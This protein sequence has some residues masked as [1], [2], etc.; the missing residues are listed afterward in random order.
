MTVEPVCLRMRGDF[1]GSVHTDGANDRLLQFDSVEEAILH[2]TTNPDF[3]LSAVLR[4]QS[5]DGRREV[6][7]LGAFHKAIEEERRSGRR[8]DDQD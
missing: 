8:S 2:A 6:M 7:A 3:E 4:V 1:L 5:V